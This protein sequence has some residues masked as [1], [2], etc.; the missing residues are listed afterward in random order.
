[1]HCWMLMIDCSIMDLGWVDYLCTF[2]LI[3]NLLSLFSNQVVCMNNLWLIGCSF[4]ILHKCITKWNVQ[5]IHLWHKRF[6]KLYTH[7]TL[8]F[9][10]LTPSQLHIWKLVAISKYAL[11]KYKYW[12]PSLNGMNCICVPTNKK[13][14]KQC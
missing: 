10:P 2:F 1:M 4:Q 7:N 13:L 8:N 9:Q 3:W 11:P 6:T 5:P 14:V 12:F